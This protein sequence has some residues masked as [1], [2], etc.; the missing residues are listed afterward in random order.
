MKITK[1][2][3]WWL[4]ISL[5]FLAL[6]YMPGLPP[7]LDSRGLLIHAALTLIPFFLVSWI[8]NAMINKNYKLK[9]NDKERGGKT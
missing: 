9:D 4:G 8:G 2:E 7:Y 3:K 6:Y 1:K 5:L